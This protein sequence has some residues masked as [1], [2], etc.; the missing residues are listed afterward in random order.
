MLV[1]LIKTIELTWPRVW[2]PGEYA[3]PGPGAGAAGQVGP[4]TRQGV[5][6]GRVQVGRLDAHFIERQFIN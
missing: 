3:P 4:C 2:V 5:K 6:Q 1:C